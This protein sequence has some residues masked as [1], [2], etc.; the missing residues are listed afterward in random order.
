M[1]KSKRN[2]LYH[3][4]SQNN[5]AT[6]RVQAQ[7]PG[8]VAEAP[9]KQGPTL[10][11]VKYACICG[12]IFHQ[13]F[14]VEDPHK[15]EEIFSSC[16]CPHCH[17][18]YFLDDENLSEIQYYETYE[19]NKTQFRFYAKEAMLIQREIEFG[20]EKRKFRSDLS[21]IPSSINNLKPIYESDELRSIFTTYA[22]IVTYNR[23]THNL[24]LSYR[25]SNHSNRVMCLNL[26]ND[27]NFNK[28]MNKM[29][30]HV[31]DAFIHFLN[32]S[33][34]LEYPIIHKDLCKFQN[35]SRLNIIRSYAMLLTQDYAK[36]TPVAINSEY[37]KFNTVKKALKRTSKKDFLQN[38][39]PAMSRSLVR[40]IKVS[41]NL[42]ESLSDEET[43]KQYYGVCSF[44]FDMASL[45]TSKEKLNRYIELSTSR[46]KQDKFY[47]GTLSYGFNCRGQIIEPA[48]MKKVLLEIFESQEKLENEIIQ[49][50]NEYLEE[51]NKI[52]D[53]PGFINVAST[54]PTFLIPDIYTNYL[55]LKETNKFDLDTILKGL[56]LEEVH[57]N[58]TQLRTSVESEDYQFKITDEEAASYDK[59]ID[60]FVFKIARSKNELVNIGQIMHHCVG[61]YGPNAYNR[62]LDIVYVKKDG[63]YQLCMEVDPKRKTINQA[64]KRFNRLMTSADEGLQE[65]L[66]AYM[67]Q[68]KLKPNN[69]YDFNGFN[70]VKVA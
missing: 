31:L 54:R 38:L 61:S 29:P 35:L 50:E 32:K 44:P 13:E 47:V 48:K 2:G 67:K 55:F 23:A 30:E 28:L 26:M 64:K 12:H 5:Y 66:R 46:S 37:R 39:V 52:N 36:H 69:S 19:E 70:P 11:E 6:A 3:I 17:H 21:R 25:Q 33:L 59:E 60:G 62:Q 10:Y 24:Y 63:K 53:Q 9:K 49:S 45:F 1:T 27:I 65:A 42:L 58:L 43:A 7:F 22:A 14:N 18:N 4:L 16:E 40:K 56:S 57:D 20:I 68:L 41:T 51:C 8:V 34:E 15:A